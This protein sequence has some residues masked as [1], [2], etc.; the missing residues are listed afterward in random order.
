MSHANEAIFIEVKRRMV[1]SGEWD[2]YARPVIMH[3]FDTHIRLNA[4]DYGGL[5]EEVERGWLDR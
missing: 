1:E 5:V 4:K 3:N 2:R